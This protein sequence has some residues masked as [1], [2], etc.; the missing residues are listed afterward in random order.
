VTGC[1]TGR[2]AGLVLLMGSL[3][4]GASPAC[5]EPWL[6]PGDLR[7]RHD[8]QLLADANVIDAPVT[9]WPLSWADLA[10]GLERVTAVTGMSAGERAALARLKARL[11]WEQRDSEL[12]FDTRLAYGDHPRR[13]KTFDATAREKREVDASVSWI[14]NR[15]ALKLQGQIVEDEAGNTDYRQDGTY[16]GMALGNLMLA[17]G[18]Q[19]RWWGPGWEGSLA[20]SSNARPVRTIALQRNLS[21][22]FESK[23]LRWLG[24]WTTILTYGTLE[25]DRTVPDANLLGFRFA[26]RPLQ[27]LE[28]AITRTAQ[29]CGKGRPC[30]LDSL[31]DLIVGKDNVGEGGLTRETE[32]GN[33]LGGFDLRWQS[34]I[35]DWPYALYFQGYAEDELD[36]RP[37]EWMIQYGLEGWNTLPWADLSLRWHLEASNTAVATRLKNAVQWTRQRYDLAYNSGAYPSGYRFRDEVIGHAMDNDGRMY[38]LGTLIVEPD[39]DSW[40]V[41]VRYVEINRKNRSAAPDSR[42][43]VSATPQDVWNVELSHSRETRFGDFRLRLAYTNT[44]DEASGK[45]E[46]DFDLGLEWSLR[47]GRR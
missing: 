6:A 17:A 36:N 9:T 18:W 5:A 3:A 23:W 16:A 7:L 29:W 37:S 24:P 25:H 10:R 27:D 12:H 31:W 32:P 15:F 26:A 42:H 8:I 20:Y 43:T 13:L 47:F 22:P 34:P 1:R 46:S 40:D 14:G 38:S 39:G 44:D 41:L 19:D 2:I 4:A 33:Q 30:D 45:T 35:T 21:R 11:D 28:I